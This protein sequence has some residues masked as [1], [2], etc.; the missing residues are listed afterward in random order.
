MLPEIVKAVNGRCEIYL[1]GG[2]CRG[3]DVFKVRL[4]S[5]FSKLVVWVR[6]F[7][8]AEIAMLTT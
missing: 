3:T 4:G 2:I 8:A 6:K 7:K 5:G 1:D